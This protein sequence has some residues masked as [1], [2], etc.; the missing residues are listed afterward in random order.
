MVPIEKVFEQVMEL[1]NESLHN[2]FVVSV[3]NGKIVARWRWKDGYFLQF[4]DVKITKEVEDYECIVELL[5]D[6]KYKMTDK[7]SQTSAAAGAGGLSLE[8]KV[9]VGKSVSFHKE[10]TIGKKN[11]TGES[12][13]VS[14]DF[15]SE[16]IHS[17]LKNF[18]ANCGYK[19]KGLFG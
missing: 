4:P 17:P 16:K 10:I 5:P 9:F 6:G 8:K 7:T 2:P 19:K 13:I 18:L 1:N 14:F 11:D 12:G 3:E 15:N